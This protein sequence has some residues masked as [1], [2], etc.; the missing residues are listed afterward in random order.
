MLFAKKNT[1]KKMMRWNAV[2]INNLIVKWKEVK[3]QKLNRCA[4][5]VTFGE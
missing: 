1:P 3:V 5:R 2:D 4:L